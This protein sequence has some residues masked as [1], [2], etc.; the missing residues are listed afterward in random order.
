[1]VAGSLSGMLL[2]YREGR[3][4]GVLRGRRDE[5]VEDAAPREPCLERD[6]GL[7]AYDVGQRSQWAAR[8]R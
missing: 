1:M 6:G 5:H 8:S 2:R 3:P 7:E 4:L